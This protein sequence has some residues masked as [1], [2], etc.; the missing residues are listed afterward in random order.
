M[1]W[2]GWMCCRLAVAQLKC[3]LALHRYLFK[4]VWDDVGKSVSPGGVLRVQ[5][6]QQQ[7][8]N[9]SVKALR[10]LSLN[11]VSFRDEKTLRI[12]YFFFLFNCR[13]LFCSI[14]IW[15]CGTVIRSP[16]GLAIAANLFLYCST[17]GTRKNDFLWRLCF[18]DQT[19]PSVRDKCLLSDPALSSLWLQR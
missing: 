8:E 6:Q 9:V 14:N 5:E 19:E 16:K 18:A 7:M 13:E 12:F 17:R 4:V 3:V 15:S 11:G 2:L 10:G 1:S